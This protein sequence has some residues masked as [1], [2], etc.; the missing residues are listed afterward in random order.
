MND[1]DCKWAIVM[2]KI[3]EGHLDKAGDL[4]AYSI[5]NCFIIKETHN[6]LAE[7]RENNESAYND[8][9]HLI[10]KVYE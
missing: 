7:A 10:I 1:N 2:I 3:K 5:H 8:S 6:T 4:V 9:N